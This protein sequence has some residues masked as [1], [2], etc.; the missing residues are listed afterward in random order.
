MTTRPPGWSPLTPA[1]VERSR[2]MS[3]SLEDATESSPERIKT[4]SPEDLTTVFGL[5]KEVGC[6]PV[7]L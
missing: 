1:W 5:T 7:R 3:Q 2:R 4:S 6:T